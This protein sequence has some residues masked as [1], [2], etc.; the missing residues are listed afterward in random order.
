MD[1]FKNKRPNPL[2]SDDLL[3]RKE[4]AELFHL[5]M[6]IEKID[7]RR[8]EYTSFWVNKLKDALVYEYSQ[9]E[10]YEL[11]SEIMNKYNTL[12]NGK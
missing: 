2:D 12:T 5:F 1:N 7:E 3:I 9:T 4:T 10:E 11:C 6:K 8:P